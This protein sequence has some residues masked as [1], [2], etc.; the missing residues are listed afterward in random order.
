M[1]LLE[2]EN[3]ERGEMD[4]GSREMPPEVTWDSV[5]AVFDKTKDRSWQLP[6]EDLVVCLRPDGTDWLLGSGGFGAVSP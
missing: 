3:R 5:Q 1:D 6:A 4:P 2:E